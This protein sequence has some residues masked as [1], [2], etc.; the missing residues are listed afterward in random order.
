MRLGIRIKK[1]RQQAVAKSYNTTYA[2]RYFRFGPVSLGFITVAMFSLV[3]FFY[4]AQA[5]QI[6]TKGYIL[7]DLQKE[8]QRILSENER[9]QVEAARLES[10]TKIR[11]KAGELSM[12]PVRD[13]K[14]LSQG[15]GLVAS[16]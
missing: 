7:Q 14:Y 13:I 10:L 9:L 1:R 8:H 11:E 3:S 6:T 16:K 2:K 15:D 5:N 12:S 4:L